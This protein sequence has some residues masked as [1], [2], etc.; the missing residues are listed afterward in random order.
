MKFIDRKK[1]I[2]RSNV[3]TLMCCDRTGKVQT[4]AAQHDIIE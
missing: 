4:A 3:K 2:N 1:H